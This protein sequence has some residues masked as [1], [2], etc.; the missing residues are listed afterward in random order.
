MPVKY[1]SICCVLSFL[2]FS[3]G[4]RTVR[5]AGTPSAPWTPPKTIIE[6]LSKDSLWDSLREREVASGRV[7]DIGDL[8]DIAL[9]NNPQTRQAWEDA[10]VSEAQAIQAAS[11]W[12]PTL[13]GTMDLGYD[14]SVAESNTATVNQSNY[15]PGASVSWLMFDFGGR[16]AGVE[17]ARQLLINANFTFNQ[18]IQDVLLETVRAYYAFDSDLALLE[19]READVE[20]SRK[21]LEDAKARLS[22]GLVSKLDE[23]QAE[24]SYKQSLYVLEDA[25]RALE[26][27]RADLAVVLGIPVDTKF[28]VARSGNE[29]PEGMSEGE[30]STM[31]EQALKDRPDISAARAVL[32]SKRVEITRVTSDLLPSVTASGNAATNWYSH[33]GSLRGAPTSYDDD[34]SYGG[35]IKVRWDIFDGFKNFYRRKEAQRDYEAE[36]QKLIAAYLNA[37]KEVWDSY[38]TLVSAKKRYEYSSSYLDSAEMSYKLAAEGY[39][40]GI[41]NIIDLLSSQ[42][43]LSDARSKF[44]QSREDV[45]VA[46]ARLL[47]AVGGLTAEAEK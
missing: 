47:H 42:S 6:K 32:E 9:S 20:D 31:I 45:F 16:S 35:Q 28:D 22:A 43:Q 11:S 5:A 33:Y 21:S 39:E 27:S 19:A 29:M 1:I 30:V 13:Q 2:L 18:T 41:K 40:A 3:S 7:F 34:Y 23:L 44:I 37:G 15:G 10:R 12:F 26:V 4:C 24:A 38:F 8:I 25:K 17:K 14:R 46:R 36:E